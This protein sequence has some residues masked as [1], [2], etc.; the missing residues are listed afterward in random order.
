M[1][2][3]PVSGGPVRVAIR[4][5]EDG[6][7]VRVSKGKHATGS[8]IPKPE[9]SKQR[10]TPR[11]TAP[12]PKDTPADVVAKVTYNP[13]R[14]VEDF[15]AFAA[16]VLGM[17]TYPRFKFPPLELENTPIGHRPGEVQGLLPPAAAAA[18]QKAKQT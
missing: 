6:T 10:R 15:K 5:L 16:N 1:L 11:P 3:D 4:R 7:N 13:E 9:A 17:P 14:L 12:G 2:V 8:I 18:L